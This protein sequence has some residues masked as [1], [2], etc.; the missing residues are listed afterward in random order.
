[1]G[2]GGAYSVTLT[3][4]HSPPVSKCLVERERKGT[5]KNSNLKIAC[6]ITYKCR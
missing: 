4:C 5:D 1:M 3:K 2:G 6:K